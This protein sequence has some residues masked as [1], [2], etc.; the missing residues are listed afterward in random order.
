MTCCANA[1]IKLLVLKL[2]IIKAELT[3]YI[4]QVI[5][6]GGACSKVTDQIVKAARHWNLVQVKILLTFA[7]NPS[8]L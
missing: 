6:F 5:L 2:T 4:W 1:N 8:E 3:D 7:P